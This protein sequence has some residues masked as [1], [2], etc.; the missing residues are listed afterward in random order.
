MLQ[1]VPKKEQNV[2]IGGKA[3][4]SIMTCAGWLTEKNDMTKKKENIARI[5]NAVQVIVNHYSSMS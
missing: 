3:W 5:A 4:I 1:K 2:G